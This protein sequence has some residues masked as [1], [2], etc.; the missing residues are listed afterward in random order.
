[1]WVFLS[2]RN[3][4]RCVIFK[5]PQRTS[6]SF[7]VLLLHMLQQFRGHIFG[8]FWQQSA[9]RCVIQP[10]IM[11]GAVCACKSAAFVSVVLTAAV[12]NVQIGNGCM[13]LSAPAVLLGISEWLSTCPSSAHRGFVY[14]YSS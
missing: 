7:D 6:G 4:Y 8:L 14:A 13:C 10:G 12:C 2:D 3:Q 5:V 11:V 9:L 1:M